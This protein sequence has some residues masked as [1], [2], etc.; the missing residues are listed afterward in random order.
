[1]KV[2]KLLLGMAIGVTVLGVSSTAQAKS[3]CLT[4]K[5]EKKSQ[6]KSAS[7]KAWARYKKE[8]PYRV[9]GKEKYKTKVKDYVRKQ[10]IKGAKNLK[11]VNS[12]STGS[13][14]SIRKYKKEV[15]YLSY[16]IEDLDFI[17]EVACSRAKAGVIS[18]HE[19]SWG[20]LHERNIYGNVTL[21]ELRAWVL[22]K[23][24]ETI[25][26]YKISPDAY[27]VG[28]YEKVYKGEYE[29]DCGGSAKVFLNVAKAWGQ[30]VKFFADYEEEH[31]WTSIKAKN[32][33]GV[34]YW[35]PITNGNDTT[36]DGKPFKDHGEVIS[37]DYFMEGVIDE[38]IR[39]HVS[40]E[41]I[42]HMG[43]LDFGSY[44]ENPDDEKAVKELVQSHLRSK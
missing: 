3:K 30:K 10:V 29:G 34:T 9:T 24:C 7:K 15:K 11:W 2:K 1:M 44:Y 16:I 32:K 6:I 13:A 18:Y 39:S 22:Y 8:K 28:D 14:S 27:F 12:P 33:K 17:Y 26:N 4:I 35:C 37:G 36:L 25:T 20:N 38:V 43:R 19:D 41:Q 23:Y 31:G 40:E 21:S 42:G 5:V